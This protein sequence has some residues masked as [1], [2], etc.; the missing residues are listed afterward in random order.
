MRRTRCCKRPPTAAATWA[1][2]CAVF[3]KCW[4]SVRVGY[5][6]QVQFPNAL[7]CAQVE[8]AEA[9]G[10]DL[11]LQLQWVRTSWA[12]LLPDLLGGKYDLAVGGIA[13]TA[14]RIASGARMSPW[15]GALVRKYEGNYPAGLQSK[16]AA[17]LIFKFSYR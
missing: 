6:A 9:L 1:W 3:A 15:P 16:S 11:G 13:K 2:R 14:E 7:D 5:G 10:K 12:A 4:G 8:I 17:E